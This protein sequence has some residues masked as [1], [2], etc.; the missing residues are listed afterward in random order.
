MKTVD[1]ARAGEEFAVKHLIDKGYT[2]LERN[3]R[4]K[5]GEIDIIAE[6]SGSVVFVEVKSRTEGTGYI[7]SEAVDS[8][9]KRRLVRLSECYISRCGEKYDGFRI[10]LIGLVF[11]AG[12]ILSVE[13]LENII[14]G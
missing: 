6:K 11:K 2:I 3:F 10:D 9:K 12:R 7:P 8:R 14:E 5:F 13:H 4:T 1:L